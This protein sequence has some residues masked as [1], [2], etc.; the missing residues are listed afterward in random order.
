MKL[1]YQ[2]LE[3]HLAK[4]LSALYLICSDELLLAQEAVDNIRA[5]ALKAGFTERVALTVE[6]G[7]DWG[8]LLFAEIHALSLFAEQRLIEINITGAKTTTATVK[9]LKEIMAAPRTNTLILI[10]T[11]KLDSRSEQ[12]AWF[13]TLEKNG[14]AI[15]IWPIALE[16]LPGWILQRA[17]KSGLQLAADAAKL[18]ADQV[19]GNLLA[20]A[21]EI[22]KLSL[23]QAD[24]DNKI[25]D[26][27]AI[28]KIMTDH[29]RYDIF[30]LVECVVAGNGSRALRI[31]DNLHA[32]GVEPVLVLWALTREVRTLAEMARQL[33]QGVPLSNLFNQFRIW[34][35]RQ[36]GIRRFLQQNT[37]RD[38]WKLLIESAKID[39]IIKGAAIGNTWNQLKQLA[40]SMAGN[41]IISL[42][43][44]YTNQ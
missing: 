18:L 13:K 25:L 36:S 14:V 2:Q 9:I 5:T 30:S 39:R 7:G 15:Q 12:A 37:Q 42:C 28:E 6:A 19:E 29:A 23:L 1:T 16:Q 8:K 11:G 22:E 3:Q 38:C 26:V 41:D 43:P 17:K 44:N 35:K 10:R 33:K 4:N 34:E 21:Q 31:I 24:G 40:L 27:A 32:E 20:A